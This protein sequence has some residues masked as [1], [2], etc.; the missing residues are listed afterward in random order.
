MTSIEGSARLAASANGRTTASISSVIIIRLVPAATEEWSSRA[1]TRIRS[2]KRRT[3]TRPA[4]E[5]VPRAGYRVRTDDI[6]LGKLTLYQ[7]S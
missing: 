1:T 7:L 3:R 2:A 5:P 4:A 6:Q